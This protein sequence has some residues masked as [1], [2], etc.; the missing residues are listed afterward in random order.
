MLVLLTVMVA[1]AAANTVTLNTLHRR[2]QI[3]DH[4]QTHR[5]ATNSPAVTK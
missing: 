3:I 5:L 1:L 4:L 2:I